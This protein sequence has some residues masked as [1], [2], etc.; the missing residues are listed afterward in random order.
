[1]A[2]PVS[3]GPRFGLP[4]P[5]FQTRVSASVHPFRTHYDASRVGQRFLIST[6]AAD[7][8]PTPITVVLNWTA[9]LKK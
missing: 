2:V 4:R 5:L 6:L 3:P 7:P 9:G 1:M 8:V